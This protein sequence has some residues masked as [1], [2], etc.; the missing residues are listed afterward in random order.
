[1]RYLPQNIT[2]DLIFKLY[3][4]ENKT[5][6]EV[7]R[8]I[9]KSPRQVC[10][11]L[12]R[13]GI[14]ARH[15]IP[16]RT[17]AVLSQE[18]KDKIRKSHIGKRIPLEVRIKMGSKGKK[19]PSYIDGRTPAN[20]LARHTTEYRLWITSV[21]ER[22]NWTCQMCHTRGGDIHAHHIKPFAKYPELR[23]SIENGLTLCKKCHRITH[24]NLLK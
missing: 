13:F 19:N 16:T 7:G 8:E 15:F 2:K 11:Y 18:T 1:M 22:D 24:K 12:K 23:T 9:N 17:G 21:F 4:E 20:K 5:L 10:R 14:Q 3:S 6:A